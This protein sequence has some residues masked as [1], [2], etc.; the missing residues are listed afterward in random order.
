MSFLFYTI[1]L[2]CIL[3]GAEV[4]L[5]IPSFPELQKV[6]DLTPFMVQ[7][8][9]SVNYIAYCVCSLFAGTMG[10]RYD[11]RHVMLGSL[12]IF[13]L[14]CILC[15]FANHFL[16]L[17]FGRL[18][19]GAGMAGPAVLAF[20][21]IADKFPLEKQPA[22]LGL[23]NGIVTMAMAGAPV[24]GSYVN[25]WFDWRGNFVVLLILGMVSLVASYYVIPNRPGNP[26]VSL[27]PKAYWPLL[28]SKKL[29]IFVLSIGIMASSYWVFIGMAP[30]LYMQGM[31][32]P[33]K[34]FG[35]YQ[36]AI[37]GA[38]SIVSILS[39]KL[40]HWLGNR[41]CFYYSILLYI[42]SV[43]LI[44]LICLL[45]INDPILI[46]GT[47]IIYA[48]SAVFPINIV[49]PSSLEVIEDSKSRTSA[50]INSTKLILTALMIQTISFFY[51]NTFLPLGIALLVMMI[52]ALWQLRIIFKNKWVKL[53]AVNIQEP[54]F[55]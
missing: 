38:F 46:S 41:K 4:D 6:F 31:H 43:A 12:L 28:T 20:V 54:H 18:L 32:V 23:L 51:T 49:Y 40:M 26:V 19:Q 53:E 50:L 22:M 10:D 7:L 5:F 44:L 35:F 30:L 25:L 27:S 13:V 2:I 14:G 3:A 45:N 47:M 21:I 29:M 33:L 39:P 36:G 37:A 34:H 1:I 17:L 11:R 42:L 55:E 16:T 52:V 9:L 48:I 8:T 24:V 15:V